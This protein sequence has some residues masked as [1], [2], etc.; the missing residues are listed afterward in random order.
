MASVI[1]I[2]WVALS[3]A[4]SLMAGAPQ[5]AAVLGYS[6]VPPAGHGLSA[7][8]RC[9]ACAFRL[10]PAAGIIPAARSGRPAS[11]PVPRSVPWPVLWPTGRCPACAAPVGPPPLSVE[12]IT[13]L[14]LLSLAA[15]ATS[16]GEVAAFG[17]LAL[18]AVPLAFVDLAAHRLPDPLTLS[19]HAGLL[20]LL[21]VTALIEHRPDDLVRAA[22]GGVALSAF[23]LLLFLIHPF[24]IGLGDV[25]LALALGS[26]LGWSGWP[27]LLA[28][29]FLTYLLGG[30]YA[31]VLVGLRRAHRKTEIPFG[32]FM[33]IGSF[34]VVLAGSG[35]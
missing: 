21:S 28:G 32:P 29:T 34:W 20:A 6:A 15:T 13:A 19:A 35:L 2:W 4:V 3:I 25:K 11:W 26:A 18:L 16:R 1:P 31:L 23:Y 30:V 17:W 5:R 14:L 8:V 12:L 10:V 24:G 27:D 9:P 22:L 33:I 7:G